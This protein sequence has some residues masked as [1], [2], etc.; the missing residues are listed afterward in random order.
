MRKKKHEEHENMERWLVSY[1]DFI[2]LLF[3]FFVVMYSTGATR[4]GKYRA[5][6]DSLASAFNPVIAFSDSKIGLTGG[7]TGTT[8]FETGLK[9]YFKKVDSKVKAM[10]LPN[11][12]SVSEDRRGIVIR[13][14][15]DVAF[16]T[17]QADLVPEFTS[18]LDEIAGEIA[19][20][21][22]QIQ[23]EGHTDNIP[24][25]TPIYPS[26]WELSTARAARIARYFAER[27]AMN[28]ERISIAG[29]GEFR[30]LASN[31]TLE[32]R[33]KNRRVEIIVLKEESDEENFLAPKENVPELKSAPEVKSAPELKI[34][35]E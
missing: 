6:S 11:K 27:H 30:P 23:I 9:L 20:L 17:G 15:E 28:P 12:I 18:R 34:G 16:E 33:A 31:E 10:N 3:A 21:P 24:I 32:G 1:A 19:K 35:P 7:R 22:N 25:K 8:M 26:N 13:V 4:E 5:V 14:V 2:T 29:Y